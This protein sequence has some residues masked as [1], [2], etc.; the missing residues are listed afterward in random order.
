MTGNDVVTA[1]A[2]GKACVVLGGG[3][4]HQAV[5]AGKVKGKYAVVPLPGVPYSYRG[6]WS[7]DR[8]VR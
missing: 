7:P 2:A 1:F 5:E 4:D 8:A 6:V 3:F